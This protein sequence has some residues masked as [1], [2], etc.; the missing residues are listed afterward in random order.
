MAKELDLVKVFDAVDPGLIAL[1]RSILVV[2][3]S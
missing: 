1:A 2:P 3:G